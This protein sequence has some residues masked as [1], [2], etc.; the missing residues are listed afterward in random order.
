MTLFISYFILI[1]NHNRDLMEELVV[2]IR[3]A[4]D[5]KQENMRRRR[6]RDALRLQL[7]R[8]L[9]K[10]AEN[11]TFGIS[12]FVLERET[13]SLHPTFVEYIDGARLYLETETDG[14]DSSSMREVKTHFCD[15]I[16]KMIKNF[17]L[18][19]CGTLL[20]RE[21]KRNLVNLFVGWSGTAYALPFAHGH[22][23]SSHHGSHHGVGAGGSGGGSISGI[24]SGVSGIGGGTIGASVWGSSSTTAGI[25]SA[26]NTSV[27]TIAAEEEKLQFSALQVGKRKLDKLTQNHDINQI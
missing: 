25:S 18:E 5:R 23:G 13:M 19:S 21:L 24:G 2:Y 3:E 11:G 7:V 12:Q 16:R 15:F 14:K 20:S 6:R 4:I 27:G 22:H 9:E 10:I 1:L 8:V 26:A 17:S